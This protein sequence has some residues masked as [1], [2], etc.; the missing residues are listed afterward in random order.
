M[1]EQEGGK[2]SDDTLASFEWSKHPLSWQKDWS[3]S[4]M[5]NEIL[6]SPSSSSD[7]IFPQRFLEGL[8]R[9]RTTMQEEL[10]TTLGAVAAND[11]EVFS[12]RMQ[13]LV[14]CVKFPFKACMWCS[15]NTMLCHHF[16]HS[17]LSDARLTAGSVVTGHVMGRHEL[18]G[19]STKDQ[20]DQWLLL[21]VS[22]P[23]QLFC[24]FHCET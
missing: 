9:G 7:V 10:R 8:L 3:V 6:M 24:V 20:K 12:Q 16:G 1:T 19:T 14:L 15:R 21:G 11:T 17:P 4:C 2:L 18:L 22:C 5:C 13:L 23:L